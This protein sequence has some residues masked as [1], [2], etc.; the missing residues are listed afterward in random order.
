MP[1][2]PF[3]KGHP[4]LAESLRTLSALART[5]PSRSGGTISPVTLWRWIR[6]GVPVSGVGRVKLEAFKIGTV[7]YSSVEA[8][9]RFLTAI[10][11]PVKAKV[12]SDIRTAK[13]EERHERRRAERAERAGRQ[14]EK[15]G[16]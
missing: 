14:L 7:T 13:Q 10:N 3:P 1:Q 11:S 6:R 12:K 9:D 2:H 5:L 16:A 8:L 4:L 15:A